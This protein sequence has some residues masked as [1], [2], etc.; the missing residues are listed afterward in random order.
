MKKSKN[1]SKWVFSHQKKQHTVIYLMFLC[2]KIRI[3]NFS[4]NSDVILL[5]SEREG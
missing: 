2:Q 1:L 5:A 4:R 3:K